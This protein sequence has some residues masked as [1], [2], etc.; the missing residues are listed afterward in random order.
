MGVIHGA[1]EFAGVAPKLPAHEFEPVRF[2]A[3]E[4]PDGHRQPMLGV[5]R[6]GQDA[7]RRVHLLRPQMQ[8]RLLPV[9][10]HFPRHSGA[11]D[12]LE[13]SLQ[14]RIVNEIRSDGATFFRVQTIAQQL[15]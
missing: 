14:F 8:E 7:A 9:T 15:F 2:G 5:I 3:A 1:S 13:A 4:A 10:A 6:N 11:I 12:L